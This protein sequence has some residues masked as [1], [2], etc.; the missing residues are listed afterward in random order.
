V[1]ANFT[2]C[3]LGF[4]IWGGIINL[5]RHRNLPLGSSGVLAS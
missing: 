5:K 3:G 2:F 1:E 4:E